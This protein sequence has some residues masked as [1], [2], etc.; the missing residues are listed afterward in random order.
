MDNSE[1]IFGQIF[2]DV[3]PLS[4]HVLFF[5]SLPGADLNSKGKLIKAVDPKLRSGAP[6]RMRD[7]CGALVNSV[8]G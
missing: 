2:E 7:L 4:R 3:L 6:W 5:V 1:N 8:L